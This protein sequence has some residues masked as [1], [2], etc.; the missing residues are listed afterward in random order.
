MSTPF[1]D[2]VE[3]ARKMAEARDSSAPPA[4]ADPTDR[5]MK[6]TNK[7]VAVERKTI[8]IYDPKLG[9]R[10]FE[11]YTAQMDKLLRHYVGEASY[12]RLAE[13]A[14]GNNV[15]VVHYTRERLWLALENWAIS[16]VGADK[17]EKRRANDSDPNDAT[18][19]QLI[20]LLTFPVWEKIGDIAREQNV[21]N[22]AALKAGVADALAKHAL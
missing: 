5:G 14:L 16:A 8:P 19:K 9:G 12:T 3:R 20:E 17:T 4:P 11:E 10:G 1:G 6:P 7:G 15:P 21:T 2:P 13:L 18:Q 22:L